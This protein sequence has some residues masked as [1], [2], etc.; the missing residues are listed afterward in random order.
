MSTSL[1]EFLIGL[2]MGP[3]LAPR[4]VTTAE[5]QAV[6]DS[7]PF[8]GL[9][10]LLGA[11]IETGAVQCEAA[12]IARVNAAWLD[13]MAWC[14]L[15]DGALT[16]VVTRLAAA[17]IDTRVLKGAAIATLD[18]PHPSWR[19]YGDVDLLVPRDA[20]LQA[21]DVLST[22]GWRAVVPPV[23]RSWT[24]RHAK[25]ITLVD[26]T[27]V[28]LDLHRLLATGPLGARVNP[29]ALFGPGDVLTVGAHR[30]MALARVHRFLHACYHAA[31][32]AT[33]GAR[34]D[35]D[36]LLLA[37]TTAAHELDDHWR[38]GWSATVVAAALLPV[39][40]WLAPSW[41]EWVR[42]VQPDPDDQRLLGVASVDFHR[43]ATAHAAA[44]EGA[45]AR[46]HYLAALAWPSRAHL[47]ARGLTRRAHLLRSLRRR[48]GGRP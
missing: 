2:G 21:A 41:Q 30:V 11:A 33:R 17:G 37:A 38:D 44:Q 46:L 10:S 43:Q 9:V 15:L 12:D 36:L 24:A 40:Q 27:G 42:G 28:Q 19:S 18:E 25:S 32:G 22:S 4:D 20:L 6:C 29:S 5:V 7:A 35:R 48:S 39:C 26:D 8:E 1:R 14:V 31:L 47:A 23:S 3:D 13:R 34:H 16:D 45:T